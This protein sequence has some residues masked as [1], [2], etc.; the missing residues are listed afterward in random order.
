[1]TPLSLI[2]TICFWITALNMWYNFNQKGKKHGN[3]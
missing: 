3:I 1:M 2:S